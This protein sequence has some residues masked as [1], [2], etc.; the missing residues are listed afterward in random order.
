MWD[1]MIDE[2]CCP[3][4][5][6]YLI[7]MQQKKRNSLRAVGKEQIKNKWL[8]DFQNRIIGP[9]YIILIRTDNP[10]FNPKRA[11]KTGLIWN[12]IW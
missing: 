12:L 1:L 2:L 8:E 10:P 11:S 7:T 4:A 3:T 9:D 6:E 5:R